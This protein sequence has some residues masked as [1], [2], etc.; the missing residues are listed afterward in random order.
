M[1]AVCFSDNRMP[2]YIVHIGHDS[3]P[4]RG[5]LYI[6][7]SVSLCP[8]V[9]LSDTTMTVGLPL[10]PSV[11][12]RVCRCRYLNVSVS[13]CPSVCLSDTSA[14]LSMTAGLPLCLSVPSLRLHSVLGLPLLISIPY[15]PNSL[16]AR[17]FPATAIALTG[18]KPAMPAH[19][20]RR[21][22]SVA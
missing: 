9:C 11:C 13:L 7:V 16:R 14:G 20:A 5:C 4:H 1:C 21:H 19:L 10:C 3:G 6:D 22:L 17:L 18:C 12:H 15:I 2:M 8:S